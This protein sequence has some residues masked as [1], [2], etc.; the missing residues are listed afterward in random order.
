MADCIR[1]LVKKSRSVRIF[2]ECRRIPREML[3]ELVDI[4]RFCPSGRN[5]QPIRYIIST[6]PAEAAAI[7]SCICWAL[8]LPDWGGPAEGENPVAYIT[9]AT[10]RD[11]VPDPCYDLGIAAQTMMLAAAERGFGGCMIGSIERATLSQYLSLPLAYEIHLV[12]AFGYPAQT[13]VLDRLPANGDPR[14][15][16]DRDGIHHVP[17][18]SLDDVL[19]ALPQHAPLPDPGSAADNQ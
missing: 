18:R 3:L 7:R 17:K 14:Y 15:W 9:M 12:L 8:D 19:L 1:S 5:R 4:A 13:I 16:R 2:D 10:A 6:D 11:A